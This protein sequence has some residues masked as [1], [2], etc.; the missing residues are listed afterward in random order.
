MAGRDI[1]QTLEDVK[2]EAKWMVTKDKSIMWRNLN[3][4]NDQGEDLVQI[5][6]PE[7]K[8]EDKPEEGGGQEPE[9][10]QVSRTERSERLKRSLIEKVTNVLCFFRGIEHEE[11]QHG[12]QW[13]VSKDDRK[14]GVPNYWQP[15]GEND[16]SECTIENI[17]DI[18]AMFDIPFIQHYRKEY[19]QPDLSAKDIWAIYD[20]DAKYCSILARQLHLSNVFRDRQ[21][22]DGIH[23]CKQFDSEEGLRCDVYGL[24]FGATPIPR[25]R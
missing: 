11:I 17:G 16:T 5:P 25:V 21:D 19:Y 10:L 12:G 14:H 3:H 2:A 4:M 20:L 22:V 15:E 1:V 24:G 8:P 7:Y 18:R 23:L 13:L 9:F 6:N